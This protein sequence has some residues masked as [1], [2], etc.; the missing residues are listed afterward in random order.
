M[1]CSSSQKKVDPFISTV[2]LPHPFKAEMNRVLVFTEV[3]SFV[4]SLTA[5]MLC[6]LPASDEWL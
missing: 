2:H 3:K 5:Q 6:C 1:L 4:S